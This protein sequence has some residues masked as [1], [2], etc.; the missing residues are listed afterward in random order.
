MKAPAGR[1]FFISGDRLLPENL[2]NSKSLLFVVF[3]LFV[4]PACLAGRQAGIQ[5]L[6]PFRMPACAS[7]TAKYYPI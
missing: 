1:G 7:M 4:I 5:V 3:A 2:L 6:G